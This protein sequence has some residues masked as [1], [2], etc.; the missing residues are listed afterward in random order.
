MRSQIAGLFREQLPRIQRDAAD[1]DCRPD[2]IRRGDRLAFALRSDAWETPC[3]NRRSREN[4]Q[5]KANS[6]G[7]FLQNK[8]NCPL[9]LDNIQFME[10]WRFLGT[11]TALQ[12][13]FF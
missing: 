3:W 8:Q 7:H 4:G 1:D 9:L 2:H 11:L 10:Q 6:T 5:Q 12:S 13:N